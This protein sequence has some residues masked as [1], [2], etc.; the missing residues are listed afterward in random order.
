MKMLS[1]HDKINDT[2]ARHSESPFMGVRN[3]SHSTRP[4]GPSFICWKLE[5]G[6]WT[7][8]AKTNPIFLLPIMDFYTKNAEMEAR[9]LGK[10]TKRTQS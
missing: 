10:K 4:S 9:K 3:L 7:L 1:M 6:R 8:I 5:A 2:A